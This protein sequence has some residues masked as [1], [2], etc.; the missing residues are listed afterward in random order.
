MRAL[1]VWCALVSR[2]LAASTK[3]AHP[4]RGVLKA[5]TNGH[6][7]IDLS[8]S[9][10]RALAEGKMVMRMN[11][12]KTSGVAVQDV[13]APAEF[14]LAQITD[15]EGYVGKV[16][17]LSSVKNYFDKRRADGSVETKATY[18]VKLVM[19]YQLEYYISQLYSPKARCLTWTLDYDR[20]SDLHDS[21]GYWRVDA[22]PE[23]PA[24]C[25]VFYSS[26]SLVLGMPQFV[27]DLLTSQALKASTAWVKKH[28][29]LQYEPRRLTAERAAAASAAASSVS[30][31]RG[32]AEAGAKGGRGGGGGDGGGARRRL[33]WRCAFALGHADVTAPERVH[34]CRAEAGEG[35]GEGAGASSTAGARMAP[36]PSSRFARGW[37]ATDSDGA[38]AW[39]N[40]VLI[41]SMLLLQC[42]SPYR[43]FLVVAS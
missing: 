22:L 28:A 36:S 1:A 42:S 2:T 12:E 16:P 38:S 30:S 39:F 18:V 14:A 34:A 10:E 11:A 24:R 26:S 43:M 6:M 5:Y 41:A 23:Q 7:A 32:A 9:E 35:E 20:K 4:H 37:A 25:R 40:L 13:A 17:G 21:V 3:E 15:G 33:S 31:G 19:G 27:M 8:A 29:E